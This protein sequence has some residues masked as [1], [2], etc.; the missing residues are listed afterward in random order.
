M[1]GTGRLFRRGQTWWIDF[2]HRGGRYRE[3]SESTRKS[4]AEAFL[5]K[6]LGEASEGKIGGPTEERVMFEDLVGLIRRDYKRQGRKS[7]PR[8][9]RAIE[10][11][12]GSFSLSRAREIT[13]GRIERHIQG[14]EDG[15][16]ATATIQKEMAA[17]KR[18]YRLALQS[19]VLSRM[20]HVP[21]PQPRNTRTN[22]LDGEPLEQVIDALPRH[23]KEITRFASITGWRKQ[24]ILGLKWSDVDTG[25]KVIRL[26]PGTTKNDEGREVPYGVLPELE[27][28]VEAQRTY[29]DQVRRKRGEITPWVFHYRGNRIND[30]RKT[31]NDACTKVGV[32]GTTF[33]DLRRTAVRNL[34]RAGVP[35]SVAMKITGHK[36]EAVYRRYA[37][38]DQRSLEEGLEKLAAF[39][40]AQYR[41]NEEGA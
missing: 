17:L 36:T 34:E 25:A 11:L 31:W 32:E 23:L 22:F 15:G 21:V 7:L 10:H 33:H 6:R 1:S 8:L 41:H 9:D 35:R 16:A 39:R 5:R 38:A 19:D 29:T 28:L 18:M 27:A 24:E 3:S 14:R 2:S 30:F 20:P 4:D 37:I 40:A 12:K 13:T 26:E